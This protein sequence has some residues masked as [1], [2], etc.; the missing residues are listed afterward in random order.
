MAQAVLNNRE[1]VF[2]VPHSPPFRNMKTKRIFGKIISALALATI[3]AGATETQAD[4]KAVTCPIGT[5]ATANASGE[6]I[7]AQAAA[8]AALLGTIGLLMLL[9]RYRR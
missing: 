9:N 4:G 1:G 3:M 8:S 2:A 6:Q 5:V 7:P